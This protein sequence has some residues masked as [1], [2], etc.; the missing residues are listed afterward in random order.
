M[1][2]ATA[3]WIATQNEPEAKSPSDIYH[4]KTK[5]SHEGVKSDEDAV[6][7]TGKTFS[8]GDGDDKTSVILNQATFDVL[9]RTQPEVKTKWISEEARRVIGSSLNLSVI[10]N[11]I[12]FIAE[13]E[14]QNIT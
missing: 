1:K 2:N 12:P 14:I 13:L 4:A 3:K 11:R 9:M 8:T 7:K 10:N 6:A 5:T